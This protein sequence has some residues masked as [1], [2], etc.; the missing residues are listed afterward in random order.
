VEFTHIDGDEVNLCVTVLARLGRGHINNLAR[1][2]LDHD[3]SG[4]VRKSVRREAK[5][6]LGFDQGCSPVLPESRAL[7]RVGE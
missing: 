2:A 7:H 4:D 3:V 6:R 5:S 1:P